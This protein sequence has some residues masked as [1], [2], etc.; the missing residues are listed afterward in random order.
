MKALYTKITDIAPIVGADRIKLA[1][2]QGYT[3]IVGADTQPGTRG[4][5]RGLFVVRRKPLGSPVWTA[6]TRCV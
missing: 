6:S 4:V 2:I 1:T 5:F 3:V